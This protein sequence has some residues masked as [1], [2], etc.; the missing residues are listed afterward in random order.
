MADVAVISVI[1]SGLVGAFGGMTAFYGQRVTL[2]TERA[3][4]LEARNDDLRSV[5]SEAAGVAMGWNRAA[6][7][8]AKPVRDS[9][10]VMDATTTA[11]QLHMANLGVRIGPR[12]PAFVAYQRL[13]GSM[14]DLEDKLRELPYGLTFE[15]MRDPV[16][17]PEPQQ[18]AVKEIKAL[19]DAVY[20]A[21]REFL[22]A[23]SVLLDHLP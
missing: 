2:R 15:G 23:G 3:K 16:R 11:M 14:F 10:E 21:M 17:L 19:S 22:A 20:T 12:S 5:L 6:G 18:V 1:S 8:L 4:R 9:A 13:Q 7:T